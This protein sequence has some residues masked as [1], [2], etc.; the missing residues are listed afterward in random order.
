[1]NIIGLWSSFNL[2]R[3]SQKRIFGNRIWETDAME[4][5]RMR[6]QELALLRTI[7]M[8][9]NLQ[10]KS[11]IPYLVK[12]ME[13]FGLTYMSSSISSA[14]AWALGE[15]GDPKA[16][17]P[18]ASN[19]FIG[20]P[21]LSS[22]S[23]QA[24]VEALGKIGDNSLVDELIRAIMLGGDETV[25]VMDKLFSMNDSES[26]QYASMK[27]LARMKGIDPGQ[28]GGYEH[29]PLDRYLEGS[30]LPL[31]KRRELQHLFIE[32]PTTSDEIFSDLSRE[33][34][35]EYEN[36][37]NLHSLHSSVSSISECRKTAMAQDAVE[38]AKR[39]IMGKYGLAV[40][41]AEKVTERF[42]SQREE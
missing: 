6:R 28:Y 11:A 9:G 1:M 13:D 15:I 30:L 26:L 37:M 25:K 2:R 8:L 7:R 4:E 14:A 31:D 34:N 33:A 3:L 29:I 27:A 22:H 16:I 18:L 5:R 23:L 39:I 32:D 40:Q 10:V 24:A 12:T 21:S 17:E 36:S 41:E 42:I 19:T 35:K 38:R 20:S